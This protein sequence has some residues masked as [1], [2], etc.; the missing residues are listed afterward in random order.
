MV[1][2]KMYMLLMCITGTACALF[3]YDRA[4][5]AAQKE[6]WAAAGEQF[7][8]LVTA[9]PDQ[10]DL[11]Y[12]AGI[13]AH[14]N[15]DYEQAKALFESAAQH[16]KAPR[17][18]KEQAYF[19]K[20]NTHVKQEQLK[21][22]LSAYDQVL[23]LNPENEQAKHNAEAVKKMLEQKEQQQQQNKQDKNKENKDQ[24]KQDQK[25]AQQNQDKS[26]QNNKDQQDNDR[27]DENE[28][29]SQK[30][31]QEGQGNSAQDESHASDKNKPKQNQQEKKGD[32]KSLDQDGDQKDDERDRPQQQERKPQRQQQR[33]R[34]N[35][36]EKN[37]QRDKQAEQQQ[38]DDH[39]ASLEKEKQQAEQQA[40]QQ[41]MQQQE[42]EQG[43][44]K[45]GA[46]PIQLDPALERVLAR[47]EDRDAQLN[48]QVIRALVGETA[49]QHGQNSW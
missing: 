38:K 19:N 31:D 21:E 17:R 1:T 40:H 41:D 16:E 28:G 10:P 2:M 23:M 27:D 32:D 45:E 3:D 42:K 9:H 13:V 34:R 25:D 18:L 36:P 24:Q 35:E 4:V 8:S 15:E 43:L 12:D 47:R 26:Q 5:G 20:A 37:S 29:Q 33:R 46:A 11:L 6:Q 30:N 22:A 44:G 39:Q 48:K 14:K 7:K 49:G